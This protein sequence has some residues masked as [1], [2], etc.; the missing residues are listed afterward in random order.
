MI[1]QDAHKRELDADRIAPGLYI[2]SAPAEETKLPFDI[3]VLAAKEYQPREAFAHIA[4]VHV[5]L[6]DNFD[7]MTRDEVA[8]AIH[9]GR[10]VAVWLR[11]GQRVLV[12][13]M[14][15]KNRSGLISA[16][17]LRYRYA[18]NATTAIQAVRRAR[19]G[20]LSN[21]RFVELIGKVPVSSRFAPS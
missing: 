4:V 19:L 14:A 10:N 18:A 7:H 2:G 9:V 17:A 11:K 12:T 15:G 20:A 8:A 1:I 6:D 5:P 21:P 3:L 13:C 16:L